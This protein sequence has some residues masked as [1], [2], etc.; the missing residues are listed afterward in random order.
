M[1]WLGLAKRHPTSGITGSI[2]LMPLIF[3]G[4]RGGILSQDKC[5]RGADLSTVHAS[6]GF[7]FYLKT[8]FYTESLFLSWVIFKTM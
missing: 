7:L 8:H 1:A 2:E 5:R 6:E 4:R 3:S